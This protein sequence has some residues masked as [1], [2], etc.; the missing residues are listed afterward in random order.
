MKR[1]LSVF[2]MICRQVLGWGLLLC[3]LAA[4]AMAALFL[5]ELAASPGTQLDYLVENCRMGWVPVLSFVLMAGLLCRVNRPGGSRVV[6]TLARLQVSEQVVFLW[7]ALAGVILLLLLWAVQAAAALALALWYTEVAETA[8]NGQTVFLAF[9]RSPTLHT[10]LPLQ[11][12][13]VLWR[14][15]MLVL[16]GGFA[17][18]CSSFCRRR[19]K[20]SFPIFLVAG[21]WAV[22]FPQSLGEFSLGAFVVGPVALGTIGCSLYR[23]LRKEGRED[24]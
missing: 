17:A 24:E 5:R 4:A 11:D 9:Y 8:A 16:A 6:Y 22:T 1:H 7:Q 18:A 15:G 19:G 10:L 12:T 13:I 23:V 2:A 21:V 20:F 3:L 14:N